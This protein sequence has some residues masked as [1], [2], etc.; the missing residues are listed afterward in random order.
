[1]ISGKSSETARSRSA[2]CLLR[3]FRGCPST[4]WPLSALLPMSSHYPS[5]FSRMFDL[6]M[7]PD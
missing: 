1:M 6:I 3:R 7:S 5:D 2:L 4:N